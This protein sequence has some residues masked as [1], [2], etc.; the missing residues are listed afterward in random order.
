M[1]KVAALESEGSPTVS[2]TSAFMEAS[3]ITTPTILKE[4]E[5]LIKRE[6]KETEQRVAL[7]AKWEA[8]LQ[9]A[10]SP[11]NLALAR[12]DAAEKE[13]TEKAA[14]A[15][16]AAVA[17]EET[18]KAVAIEAALLVEAV[19]ADADKQVDDVDEGADALEASQQ[20]RATKIACLERKLEVAKRDQRNKPNN[21]HKKAQKQAEVA[22]FEALAPTSTHSSP[23]AAAMA[24]EGF[25]HGRVQ[26]HHGLCPV[27]PLDSSSGVAL[28]L[29]RCTFLFFSNRLRLANLNPYLYKSTKSNLTLASTCVEATT[30]QAALEEAA[31]FEVVELNAEAKGLAAVMSRDNYNHAGPSHDVPASE[32]SV[33]AL[34]PVLPAQSCLP[35]PCFETLTSHLTPAYAGVQ[36]HH[37]GATGWR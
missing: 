22:L 5:D 24:L 33:Q 8:E 31:L 11:E 16:L 20:R 14:A 36:Y 7:Q 29:Q 23:A 21:K 9:C 27:P 4:R 34:S 35:S 3:P 12:A 15:E 17:A 10:K 18:A 2:P 25:D 19:K 32:Q 26:C 1:T 37:A 30:Q 28:Q 6:Y 13:A